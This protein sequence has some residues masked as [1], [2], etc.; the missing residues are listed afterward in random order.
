MATDCLL[1]DEKAVKA[2]FNR[3]VA[4]RKLFN[5][6]EATEDIKAAIRLAPS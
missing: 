4:N 3:A 2:L 6:D 5:F 1:V